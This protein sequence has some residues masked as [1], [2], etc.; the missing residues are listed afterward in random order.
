MNTTL[1]GGVKVELCLQLGLFHV[2]PLFWLVLSILQHPTW[3]FCT[4][5]ALFHILRHLL[6]RFVL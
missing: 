2:A 6:T 3:A 5:T 4:K 1:H